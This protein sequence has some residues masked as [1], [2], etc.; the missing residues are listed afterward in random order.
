MTYGFVSRNASQIGDS[1]A[2]VVMV[3]MA[4]TL[5]MAFGVI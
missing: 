4:L 1:V 2:C 5:L 3:S